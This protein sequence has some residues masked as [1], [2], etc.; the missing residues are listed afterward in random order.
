MYCITFTTETTT[1]TKIM[2]NA[3]EYTE[4]ELET[5]LDSLM[6]KE[7]TIEDDIKELHNIEAKGKN[8][9]WKIDGEINPE[10]RVWN[11]K[12][13]A[14]KTEFMNKWGKQCLTT[15]VIYTTLK[16]RL[17]NVPNNLNKSAIKLKRNKG[18]KFGQ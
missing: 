16:T 1:K 18:T 7:T 15:F 13:V 11:T 2:T 9:D 8:I 3:K 17:A 10:Y 5:K 14:A 6:N 12:V 4:K